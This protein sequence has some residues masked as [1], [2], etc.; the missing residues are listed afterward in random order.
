MRNK[1]SLDTLGVEREYMQNSACDL[2]D[3]LVDVGSQGANGVNSFK[4]Y[5]GLPVGGHNNGHPLGASLI[6]LV[7]NFGKIFRGGFH[8]GCT[9]IS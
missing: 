6:D 5:D 4:L 1:P 3:I 9:V 2:Y 7:H 8:G